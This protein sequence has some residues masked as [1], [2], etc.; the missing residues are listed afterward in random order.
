MVSN[1]VAERNARRRRIEVR[2]RSHYYQLQS[3]ATLNMYY[4]SL[5]H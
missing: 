1:M 3:N 2:M 5:Q 4:M